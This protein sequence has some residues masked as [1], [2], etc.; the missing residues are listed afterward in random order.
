M[1]SVLFK[2]HGN[3]RTNWIRVNCALWGEC[4]SSMTSFFVGHR[5]A[6]VRK[7]R[8][9]LECSYALQFIRFELLRD[10]KSYTLV[11]TYIVYIVYKNLRSLSL[12]QNEL[13]RVKYKQKCMSLR[14]MKYSS[15]AATTVSFNE[16]QTSSIN[17]MSYGNHK[18]SRLRL[19][20]TWTR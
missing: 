3:F 8:N 11:H 6:Q 17:L 4:T 13:L 7:C 2:W 9:T 1:L 12:E 10:I 19:T 5:N 16:K 15:A 18:G 20:C 14:P